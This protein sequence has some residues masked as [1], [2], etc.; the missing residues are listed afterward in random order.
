V[1]TYP[2]KTSETI[3]SLANGTV[4]MIATTTGWDINPRALGQVPNSMKVTTL[5]GFHWVTDAHY[6]VVPRGITAD[7]LSAILKLLQWMLTPEQQAKAYDGGYLYPGPA[8]KGVTLDMAPAESQRIIRQF[9]RP[10]YD[11]LIA[12]RP[13][14]TSLPAAQQVEAFNIWDREI[15][16]GKFKTS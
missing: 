12:S 16:S 7:R 9:G 1:P 8:I 3:Q 15:G 4:D 14:Q 6:A 11:Q 2:T 5:K 10:E 13:K